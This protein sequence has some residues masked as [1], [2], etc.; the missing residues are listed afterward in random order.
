MDNVQENNGCIAWGVLFFH[1][2]NHPQ[3]NQPLPDLLSI[4]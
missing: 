4:I 3:L 1:M 2:Y